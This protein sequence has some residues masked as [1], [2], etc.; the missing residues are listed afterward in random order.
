MQSCLSSP[1][2][3]VDRP[4]QVID[5]PSQYELEY[6]DLKLPTSDGVE[7][8]CYLIKQ[9]GE[10]ALTHQYAYQSHVLVF[11]SGKRRYL[12]LALPLDGLLAFGRPCHCRCVPRERHEYGMLYR[13]R[14]GTLPTSL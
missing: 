4:S 6:E 13:L 14:K 3:I 10:K 11:D 1:D 12:P 8:H 7:L 5:N 9:Q 2:Y